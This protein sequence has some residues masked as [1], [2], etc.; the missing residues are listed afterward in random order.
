MAKKKTTTKKKQQEASDDHEDTPEVKVNPWSKVRKVTDMEE[1]ALLKALLY[2][3]SGAGKSQAAALFERPL[4]G[5]TE[6][7]AVP[8]IQATNPDALIY[9][10]KSVEDVVGFTRL[11]RHPD[12]QGRCDAVVLDSLTDAQ[13]IIRNF[14]TRRQG[15]SAGKEKTSMESWGLTIDRTAKVARDLRDVQG[16]HVVLICLD[17]EQHVDGQGLVHRPGVN[18]K[19]LPNDL[20]QYVNLVGYL[21]KADRDG[22]I[23]HEVMFRGI[24]RYLTKGIKGLEDVEPPEPLWWVHKALGRECPE[25]VLARVDDWRALEDGEESDK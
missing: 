3:P 21:H 22:G 10:I 15:D 16:M 17:D 5:L 2:G 1:L 19:R 25:E 20:A 24:D 12:T 23:R 4:I 11:A 13:R 14:Y 9:P 8:T 7:Q 6:M 18:G